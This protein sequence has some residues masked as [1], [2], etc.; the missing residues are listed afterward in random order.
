M[1]SKIA[2]LVAAL[3]I[4]YHARHRLHADWRQQ[5]VM[6]IFSLEGDTRKGHATPVNDMQVLPSHEDAPRVIRATR[7]VSTFTAR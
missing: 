3:A 1:I 6:R 7:H 4:G 5:D 2:I